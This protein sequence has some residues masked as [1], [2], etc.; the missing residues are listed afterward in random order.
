MGF[1]RFEAG[2][3]WET[4]AAELGRMLFF[5]LE[6]E[7]KVNEHAY[8]PGVGIRL[9]ESEDRLTLEARERTEMFFLGLPK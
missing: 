5:V 4:G 9:S 6:G 1:Y 7:G 8:E 2:A 3:R